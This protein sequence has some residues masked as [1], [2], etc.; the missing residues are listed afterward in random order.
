MIYFWPHFIK[1]SHKSR[2]FV[3]T[4][5]NPTNF[6]EQ[7]L[8]EDC[9]CS[10]TGG[11]LFDRIVEKGSYSEKDAA[12]LIKQVFNPFLHTW[13]RDS[14][15]TSNGSSTI[16][17]IPLIFN[18]ILHT[19]FSNLELGTRSFFRGSLSAPHSIFSPGSLTLVRSFF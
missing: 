11:E 17:V 5:K 13:I 15:F 2:I 3:S 6:V 12:D 7:L 19:W 18:A 10:V 1:F 9:F 16:Q 4:L 8:I 14:C